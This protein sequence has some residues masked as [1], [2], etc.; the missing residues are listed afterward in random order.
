[1]KQVF[2]I[3]S[4]A[5]ATAFVFAGSAGAQG[6][7]PQK[8]DSQLQQSIERI[9]C[10][11]QELLGANVGVSVKDLGGNTIAE[12]NADKRLVPA[13]NMKLVTTGTALQKLGKDYTFKTNLG[14]TGCIE[15]G[16]LDGDLYIIGGGDPTT[17]AKDS[18]M[19]DRDDSFRKWKTLLEQAGIQKINGRII[20]DPHAWEGY[21]ELGDWTYEDVGTYY[22]TGNGALNY[23]KNAIDMNVAAASL[24][25]E[26]VKAQQV[27][28][29]TPWMHFT[30]SS[31]TGR[32]GSGNS[33]YLYTTDLAPY[34]ELRGSFALDRAPKTEHF[35][36][37]FGALTCAHYFRNYLIACGIQV[38]GEAA[39]IDRSGHI[40]TQEFQLQE[41]AGNPNILATDKSCPLS[42]IATATNY[43]S[44]NFYAEAIFRAIG[45]ETTQVAVYDSAKVAE[46]AILK[47]LGLNTEEITIM[48]GSGLSRR[49]A[50]TADFITAFLTKMSGNQAFLASLPKPGEGT[51]EPLLRKH[52][53]KNRLRL[54]S[55]SMEGILCYSGYILDSNGTP[56]ATVSLLVNGAT[57]K[58]SRIRKALESILD[59]ILCQV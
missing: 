35:A 28:P 32:E 29:E 23:Y 56:V 13:S 36:N 54:K 37:K 18:L 46:K 22:G 31:I 59:A 4:L 40:R 11:S 47:Q 49:N 42:E 5:V 58:T 43:Y 55:G 14:Y 52:P 16:T 12:Y 2:V 24:E 8:G 44:D 57:V 53:S 45:E 38:E 17:G 30:N 26:P 9:I 39:D 50:V 6:K 51:I 48:D 15:G 19:S 33:L 27:F 34:S 3:T 10:Q 7:Q 25:G 21:L 41:E 1:M 20:G